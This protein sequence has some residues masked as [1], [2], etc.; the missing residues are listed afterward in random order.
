VYAVSRVD[1]A[2]VGEPG[3]R[4]CST[5]RRSVRAI[6]VGQHGLYT[7]DGRPTIG[8]DIETDAQ[9]KRQ[10]QQQGRDSADERYL[11]LALFHW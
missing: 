4:A 7:A 6:A 9:C 3:T 11:S 2:S 8:N 10:Q 5:D 1:D